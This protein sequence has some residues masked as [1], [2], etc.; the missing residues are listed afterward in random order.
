M[1]SS[2]TLLKES[3]KYSLC[4]RLTDPNKTILE[5]FIEKFFQ[6]EA[7]KFTLEELNEKFGTAEMAFQFFREYIASQD[8]DTWQTILNRKN[9]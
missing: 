7:D 4:L 6:E 5:L 9:N 8:D 2:I 1:T 3:L